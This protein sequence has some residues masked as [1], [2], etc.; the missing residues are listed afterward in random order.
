MKYNKI[1]NYE[2]Y[3]IFLCKFFTLTLIFDFKKSYKNP[4]VFKLDGIFIF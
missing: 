1:Q 2:T 3:L 4:H